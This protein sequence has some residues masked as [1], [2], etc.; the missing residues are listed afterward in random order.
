MAK[1]TINV[2]S[3]ANDG[4][5]DTLRAAAQKVNSNFTEVYATSQASFEK[6]NTA[7]DAVNNLSPKVQLAWNTANAAF[8]A[9]NNGGGGGGGNTFSSVILTNTPDNGAS[10]TV[11]YGMGD[12][13]AYKDGSYWVLGEWNGENFGTQGIRINPGI[14]GSTDIIMPAD[15][16]AANVPLQIVNYAGDVKIQS[17][18]GHYWTFGGDGTLTFPD[19]S[20]QTTAAS[21]YKNVLTVSENQITQ[22]DENNEIVF[23][24]A[25]AVG[26]TT[27]LYLPNNPVIGQSITVKNINSG[28]H[29][30]SV[31]CNIY[32]NIELIN[33]NID[34]GGYES[35]P[36]TGHAATWVWDG[37]TW[38][39]I[40]YYTG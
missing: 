19:S 37:S 21:K 28:G 36:Q 25:N 14:E 17:L 35:L 13:I 38:R 9:A 1:Q 23:C 29:I 31:Q 32:Q 16:D 24:D 2:G 4:T 40:S 33:H 6:A 34:N 10:D 27:I 26:D 39:I 20:T 7:S 15:S 12:F 30:V 8:A 22:L 5:G 18:A 3:A 11:Q